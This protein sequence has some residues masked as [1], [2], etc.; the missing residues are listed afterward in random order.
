VRFAITRSLTVFSA[1]VFLGV[2]ARAGT[3]FGFTGSGT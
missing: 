1:A 3:V 2:F